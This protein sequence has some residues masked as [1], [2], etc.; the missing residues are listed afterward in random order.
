[1][2]SIS[3]FNKFTVMQPKINA[4]VKVYGF[5]PAEGIIR[6]TVCLDERIAT[7]RGGLGYVKVAG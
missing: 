2:K 3:L 7:F 6:G 4:K 5:D 1:V